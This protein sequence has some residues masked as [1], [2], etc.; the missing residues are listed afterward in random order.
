[1]A[2]RIRIRRRSRPSGGF[3]ASAV[4]AGL[5]LAALDAH[6]PAGRASA[7]SGTPGKAAAAAI[8][9]ARQQAGKPYLWG[10]TGPDAFDCSGLVMMAYRSAG[11]TIA[12]T[13][14]QQWASER[15]VSGP[16]PG[17]L[18]FYAGSDGTLASPGHVALVAGGGQMI[19]AYG[20]GYPIRQV[21]IRPGWVGF[22]DP[23][24]GGG[25]G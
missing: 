5:I 7:A 13:S 23:A 3:V 6:S 2:H 20:T 19:E 14:Q 16:R 17:D 15:H 18:V 9:Y 1:L 24:A 10:G 12:R 11:V 4:T 21:P 22:T 8:G 25:A